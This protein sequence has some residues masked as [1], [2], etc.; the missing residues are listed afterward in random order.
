MEKTTQKV[1]TRRIPTCIPGLDEMLEGGF[2]KHSTILVTGGC[3]SG[4]TTLCMQ[5]LYGGA[6]LG[7]PGIYITF[8]E[9]IEP[10]KE[11]MRRHGWDLDKLIDDGTLRILHIAPKDVLHIVQEDYGP[12]ADGISDIG[13]QRVVIDSIS[14]IELM[15]ENEFEGRRH[16]L[17]LIEWLRNHNCTSLLTAEAEQSINHYSR[18]GVIEFIVDGVIVMYNLRRESIRHRAI[19][20][21][22]MRGTKHMAKIV[23]F[24]INNGIEL[25]PKQKLFGVN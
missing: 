8:E 3:G 25:L 10:M 19:E 21:L 6:K 11:D 7:Q 5:Y 13:A 24:M 12:I 22:K 17:T 18:H 9:E 14:S 2:K 16:I 23:P 4:K 20:I 1:G 15:V